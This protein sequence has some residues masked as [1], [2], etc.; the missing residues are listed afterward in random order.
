MGAERMC[1]LHSHVTQSP[2]SDHAYFPALGTAPVAHGRVSC[3]SGTKQRSCPGKVKVR[4][5]VENETLVYHDAVRVAAV[6]DASEMFVRKVVSEGGI[7]AELFE[8]RLA[9]GAGPVGIHHA[10]DCGEVSGLELV[11]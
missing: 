10:S 3:D 1:E 2:E 6:S 8:V 9:L 4:G 5:N 7:R 11:N